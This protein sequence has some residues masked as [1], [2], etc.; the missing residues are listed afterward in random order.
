MVNLVF[1]PAVWDHYGR[2]LIEAPAVLLDGHVE[3]SHGATNLIV[4][5]AEAMTMPAPTARRHF[6]R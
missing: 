5:K 2:T 1:A 4:H 3:R 6:G